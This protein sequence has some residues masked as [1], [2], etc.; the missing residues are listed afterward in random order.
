MKIRCPHCA[1][2]VEVI[3]QTSF[4]DIPCEACG[5]SFSLVDQQAGVETLPPE[6]Q[7]IDHF[8]LIHAVGTGA[9]GTVYKAKDTELDR[10]VAVKI[11]RRQNM[12]E[13]EQQ[14][15]LREARAAAQLT[16]RNIVGVH[17]VG[18]DDETLYIVSDF[19]EGIDL[20]EKLTV[21]RYTPR[22]A[23]QLCVKIANALEH[24]HQSGVIHR[25]LKPSNIMLDLSL[26]HI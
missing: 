19:V 9:Y 14:Q 12:G 17:E 18:R 11:P 24:A 4:E 20:A 3:E 5:S 26:I 10:T 2:A 25:D 8:R 23:V 21:D 7:T 13:E 22:Q 6:D 15:F 16:H 1:N